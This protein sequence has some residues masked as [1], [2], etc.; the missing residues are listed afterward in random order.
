MN[1]ESRVYS[2]PMKTG[3]VIGIVV[4]VILGGW[5]QQQKS[6]SR[7]K[8][9]VKDA[10]HTC[11]DRTFHPNDLFLIALSE[12]PIDVFIEHDLHCDWIHDT[13]Y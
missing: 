2:C 11:H 5:Y 8:K 1:T 10:I 12:E 3:L 9:Q 6:A 4:G 7:L 13:F